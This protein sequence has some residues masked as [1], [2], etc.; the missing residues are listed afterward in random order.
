MSSQTTGSSEAVSTD[1]ETPVKGY[2]RA[3]AETHQRIAALATELGF[4]DV[5]VYAR[6]SGMDPLIHA[7]WRGAPV[8][9]SLRTGLAGGFSVAFYTGPKPIQVDEDGEFQESE[10][11]EVSDTMF[12]GEETALVLGAALLERFGDPSPYVGTA[13]P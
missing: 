11:D 10:W 8:A 5:R 2:P 1:A 6:N 12:G 13:M 7:R 9:L 3:D 4:E